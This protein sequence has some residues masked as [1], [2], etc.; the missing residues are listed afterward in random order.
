[1]ERGKFCMETKV[2]FLWSKVTL[3]MERSTVTFG[4]SK[5][6]WGQNVRGMN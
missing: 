3:I 5:T 2:T 6:V 4:W 1:M